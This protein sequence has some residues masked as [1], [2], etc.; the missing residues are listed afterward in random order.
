MIVT[1][2][3]TAGIKRDYGPDKIRPFLLEFVPQRELHYARRHH[4][5]KLPKSKRRRQR[6]A[7]VH[8]VHIVERVKRFRPEL[9]ALPF[10][11]QLEYLRQC[12]VRIEERRQA[13]GRPCAAVA[14]HFIRE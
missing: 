1:I 10:P 11:G 7:G 6:Q 13:N 5:L 9:Y 4:S 2:A 14:R 12:E 3:A 8:E